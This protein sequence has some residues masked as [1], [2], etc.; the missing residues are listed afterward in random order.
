[1]RQAASDQPSSSIWLSEM[2]SKDGT[3]GALLTSRRQST[4]VP[5]VDFRK[6]AGVEVR[7]ARHRQGRCYHECKG[8]R[9]DRLDKHSVLSLDWESCGL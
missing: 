5:R 7:R 8:L 6:L 4:H 1:M 2:S 3:R 9:A